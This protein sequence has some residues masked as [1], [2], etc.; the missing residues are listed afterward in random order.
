MPRT[1]MDNEAK[2]FPEGTLEELPAIEGH[3]DDFDILGWA[4]QP[5]DCVVFIPPVAGG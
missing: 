1:F 5:G 4:L 2:W 3:R